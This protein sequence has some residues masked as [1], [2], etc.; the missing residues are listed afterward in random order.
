MNLFFVYGSGAE[1]RIVTP[2]AT[3]SL[4]LGITRDSLLKLGPD[5]G[6]P[7]IEDRVSVQEWQRGCASGEITEAFACGTAAVITPIGGVRG[8]NAEW[9]IGD[10]GTGPVTTRLREELVGIQNGTRPD[11]YGWM[12]SLG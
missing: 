6:I 5:L 4:L 8:N 3:G 1:A 12:H 11:R 10:G 2:A 7:A 9:V